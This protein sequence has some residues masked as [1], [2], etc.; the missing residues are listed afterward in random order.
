MRSMRKFKRHLVWL[1]KA[2]QHLLSVNTPA[3]PP[4]PGCIL[5]P[6]A[7]KAGAD[8]ALMLDP[9]GFVATCNSTNFAI[10]RRGEVGRGMCAGRAWGQTP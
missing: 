3:P 10:V 4:A 5:V 1:L 2:Y 8:E 7:A 9:S 6:Q